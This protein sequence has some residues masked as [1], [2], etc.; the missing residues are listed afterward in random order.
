MFNM[1][2]HSGK[3]ETCL[4]SDPEHAAAHL[5]TVQVYPQLIFMLLACFYVQLMFTALNADVVKH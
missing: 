3:D 2:G 1:P 4:E 5:H